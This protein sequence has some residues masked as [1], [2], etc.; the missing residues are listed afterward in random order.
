MTAAVW[1]NDLRPIQSS[2]LASV[3]VRLEFCCRIGLSMLTEPQD[4]IDPRVMDAVDSMFL[5]LCGD[6]DFGSQARYIDL[7]GSDGEALR[8]L[9]GYVEQD[10]KMFRVVTIFVPILINDAYVE[11]A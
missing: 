8:A 11:V 9:A 1:I 4:D 3:S 10:S 5:A 6:F 2:G 7:L